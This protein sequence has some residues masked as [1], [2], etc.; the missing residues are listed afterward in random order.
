MQGCTHLAVDP[1]LQGPASAAAACH[2]ESSSN[3]LCSREVVSVCVL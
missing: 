3:L 1:P 2:A